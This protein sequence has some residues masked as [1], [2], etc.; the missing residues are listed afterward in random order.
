MLEN[1]K[2]HVST[3]FFVIKIVLINAVQ[4]E[5]NPRNSFEVIKIVFEQKLKACLN[6]LNIYR[7]INDFSLLDI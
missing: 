1:T 2:Q 6:A 4:L 3:E 7:S 5:K